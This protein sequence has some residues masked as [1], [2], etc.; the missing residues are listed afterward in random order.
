MPEIFQYG[1]MVRALIG[2]GIIGALAPALGVFL[3]LRR[4]SLIADTLSHVALA[5]VAIGMLT[6][7]YP[8]LIALVVTAG[9]A[10]GIEQLRVRRHQ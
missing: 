10:A 9:A 8:P 7:T 1:F 6:R 2:A 5:G 3:V 4:L